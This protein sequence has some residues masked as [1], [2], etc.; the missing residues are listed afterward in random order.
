MTEAVASTGLTISGISDNRS[1]YPSGQVPTYE[2]FEITFQ[3][4]NTVATNFAMPYD[5]NPPPGITPGIGITVNA[6]F[7]PDNFQT[8]STLPAFYYQD[9]DYQQIANTDWLYPTT[10]Y[11]WKVRFAPPSSGTWQYRLTAQD[12]SG[13]S[14]SWTFSFNVVSSTNHGFIRVAKADRRYFEFDDGT[15]FPGLGYNMNFANISWNNPVLDNQHNFE[16]MGQNGIQLIRHWISQWAIFGSQDNPW[17]SIIQG[18]DYDSLVVNSPGNIAPGSEASLWLQVSS[19]F[20]TW[21]GTP[22]M[23]LGWMKNPPAVKPNT[24]YHISVAYQIS[25]TFSGPAIA[26]QPYGLVAKFADWLQGPGLTRPSDNWPTGQE[27]IYPAAL[28]NQVNPAANVVPV[29]P[30]ASATTSGWATLE[31]DFVTDSST[32]QTGGNYLRWLYLAIEN[33]LT[34]SPIAYIDRVEIMENL[35]GG[36]YGPNVV[37]KPWMSHLQYFDQRYSYA[38]DQVMDL[39]N[40]NNIYLK[41][42]GLEKNEFIQNS[43]D[44]NGNPITYST[45]QGNSNFYGNWESMTRTRWLQQAY[46]RYLQARWGYSTNI[47]S[48]ELLNEGDP[49]NGQHYTLADVFGQYMHQFAPNSHLVTTSNWDDF[50]CTQFWA[51]PSYPNVDYADIHQYVSSSDTADFDDTALATVSLSEQY[52]ALTAGGAGKP[53]IRG[54][55]G[56]TDASTGNATTQYL[57]DT[58]G[59]WLHKFVWA[60]INAGGLIECYWYD[61]PHIHQQIYSGDTYDY[62]PV[63]NPYYNFIK[64]IPLNNG[65]YQDAQ[66][67]VLGGSLEVLGQKDL[68]GQRAHLWINNVTHTWYNVV[69]NPAAIVPQ[70]GTITF[71]MS[72]NVQYNVQSYDTYAGASM[73]QWTV[74]AD[75][76]GM[77]SLTVSNLGTDVAYTLSPTAL[78][79]STATS[80][81]SATPT[82]TRTTV[83]AVTPTATQ[84]MTQTPTPTVSPVAV[85]SGDAKSVRVFLPNVGKNP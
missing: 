60:Q 57:A 6:E 22:A 3:V 27:C 10:N 61:V 73:S 40:Q 37:S 18:S 52:G 80:V 53:I 77:I 2:K 79:T 58:S 9:F 7:S 82:T 19:D 5:K 81:V 68:T 20:S 44:F 14:T 8:I 31:G 32:S 74:T 76:H 4:T 43:Y 83:P 85:T 78:P 65:K 23:T 15:Y 45:S 16:V 47:H 75:N 11:A 54:E 67:T 30:Y 24:S 42:V 13:T 63:Y 36:Q 64:D 55:I 17:R 29:T 25:Q 39:A 12:A 70:S 59:I 26:G 34:G 21:A 1:D 48:W 69:N 28:T 66:A 41:L 50:P 56:F 84:A 33:V 49:W 71:Q 72:P 51:N 62:R 35:G 38:F 46:W